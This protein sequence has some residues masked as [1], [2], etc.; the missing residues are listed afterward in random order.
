MH[1]LVLISFFILFGSFVLNAQNLQKLE[2]KFEK[3]FQKGKLEK[4]EKR[5]LKLKKK[6]PQLEL[7]YYYLARVELIKYGRFAQTPNKKQ[8]N[9]L[10][11]ASTYSK[12]LGSDY[13]FWKDSI[14]QVYLS[15]IES[16]NDVDYSSAHLKKVVKAYSVHTNDTLSLYYNYYGQSYTKV[17]V[18]YHEI[19]ETG[20]LRTKLI[21]FA[22]ELVGIPYKYAGETP[23]AGFDCSG[24][25]KY[26]YSSI[27][28][29]LPHN[30]H[31]QSQLEGEIISI[32]EA[33][34]GDLIFFGSRN[35]KSWSTQHAGIIYEYKPNEPKVIHCVSRG[36]SIDG[37]NSSWDHYWK[38]RILFVKRLSELE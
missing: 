25:V 4:V 26:V 14:K 17:D 12:K 20:E 10:R 3:S 22:S 32:E 24:F 13:A 38:E 15:Y 36:V 33:Q 5:A 23:E 37:N 19:P 28:L 21:E 18:E 6:H 9:Y 30:A 1:K 11:K 2:K 34:P 16:W 27:G 35:G 7:L 8:W 29:E 31:M